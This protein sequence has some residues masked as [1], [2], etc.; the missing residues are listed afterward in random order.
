MPATSV[1]VHEPSATSSSSTG[2]G[3]IDR[4]LSVSSAI[5]WPEGVTPRNKSS[6]TN[7][8]SA[9]TPGADIDK[10]ITH[11][12]LKFACYDSR[13]L[14]DPHN[15]QKGKLKR[16]VSIVCPGDA[17]VNGVEDPTWPTSW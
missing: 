9:L 1:A 4:W 16:E 11:D 5:A 7:R 17:F 13:Q 2:E 15:Q 8:T 10:R 14:V 12:F 6:L 3:A